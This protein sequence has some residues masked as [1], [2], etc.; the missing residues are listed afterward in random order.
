MAIDNAIMFI[1]N[2][3]KGEVSYDIL[4][5]GLPNAIILNIRLEATHIARL[6]AAS[7]FPLCCSLLECIHVME[8]I[9][10]E[11]ECQPI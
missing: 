11:V 1:H 6:D 8:D 9:L 7:L 10:A 3:V 2:K 5:S 4:E